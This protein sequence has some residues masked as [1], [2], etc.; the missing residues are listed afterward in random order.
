MHWSL[1]L[2][3]DSH[4]KLI[5]STEQDSKENGVPE[6]VELGETAQATSTSSILEHILE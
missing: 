6:Q 1:V 5:A 2:G 3:I 4:D